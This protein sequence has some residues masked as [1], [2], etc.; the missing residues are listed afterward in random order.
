MAFSLGALG[1]TMD[2]LNQVLR[3]W[4]SMTFKYEPLCSESRVN[5]I[6]GNEETVISYTEI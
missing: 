6:Q 2:I 5:V 1:E 3:M 4:T